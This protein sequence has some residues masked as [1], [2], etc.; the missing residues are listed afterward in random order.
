MMGIL[1]LA[2]GVVLAFPAALYGLRFQALWSRHRRGEKLND[3]EMRRLKKNA[4]I[5][6][7]LFVAV[8]GLAFKG[9][10]LFK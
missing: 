1:V 5:A 9:I 2:A 3:E 7:V 6:L 4:A 8:Y 10:A